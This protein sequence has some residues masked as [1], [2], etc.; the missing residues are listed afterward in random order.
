MSIQFGI[1]NFDGQTTDAEY[2]RRAETLLEPF[3]P[4]GIVTV[5]LRNLALML[6]SLKTNPGACGLRPLSFADHNWLLWD[7]RIDNR[8]DLFKAASQPTATGQDSELIANLYERLGAKAF[9][10][11]VG[12]WSAS[13]CCESEKTLILA[14]DYLGTRPLFYHIDGNQVAWCTVLEPLIFLS[15][16]PLKLCESYLAGWMAFFPEG[17]LTPYQGIYSVPP[18]SFVQ[19]RPG[20]KATRRYW[21]FE[22]AKPIRYSTD[23][24][25][26]EHFLS[27]FREAVRRRI[28]STEP[29]LA[30]L[31]GGM[32]SSSIVC[33]A[34]SLLAQGG[35][36][37]PRIDT[38][39]YCDA[40]ELTWDEMPLVLKVETERGRMGHHIEIAPSDATP[41]EANR[42]RFQAI[43]TSL[44]VT[45]GAAQTFAS[46]VSR[47]RHQV[48]L[49][50]L[51]GD[52]ILGGV[53]T[54]IP[55]LADLHARCR[56]YHFVRQ[57][58]RWAVAKKKPVVGLW[59]TTVNQFLPPNTDMFSNSSERI[60]WLTKEFF[61]RN[62]SFLGFSQPRIKLFGPLPSMQVNLWSLDILRRQFAC[63]PLASQPAYEWRYPFMDR[64]LVSFC[65]S[66]PREQLVRPQQRRS[67]MRRALVGLVP[68]E[69]LERRRKAYVTRGL[70]NAL[71]AEWAR[72]GGGNELLL[73]ELGIA[74]C[75]AVNESIRHAEQGRDVSIV[76]L[77][78]TLAMEHWLR[79]MRQEP[80]LA[81][82]NPLTTCH[83]GRTAREQTTSFSAEK[84]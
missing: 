77:L 76:P 44:G 16:S 9:A 79:T 50:G 80:Q 32:D 29:V 6:G 34:D 4:D 19:I 37:T 62:E 30:E 46:L 81:I 13:I 52:E 7:G 60:T 27:V 28:D 84:N 17:H 42:S 64:D 14:K 2:L 39:T 22:N 45:T 67:L 53:P 55:E 73:E 8:T 26:E 15:A 11:I 21:N 63:T 47:G 36:Q 10:G 20:M 75:A 74:N 66:V 43:P 31:S 71:R 1:W 78:R 61:E 12:D 33:M 59:R 35:P 65:F 68:K 5:Q 38:V 24:Q 51:G 41:P 54:P 69:V 82:V 57:S 58:V 70:V 56:G 83:S 49:S 18:S 72:L 40:T 3:A 25:Y 48:V 23:R